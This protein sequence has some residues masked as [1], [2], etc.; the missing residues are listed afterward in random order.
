MADVNAEKSNKHSARAGVFFC[1]AGAALWGTTGTAQA[2]APTGAEPEVVGALRLVIGGAV[3][4]IMAVLR[5]VLKSP[6]GWPIWP[7]LLAG[8][9]MAAYQICFFT[10]VTRTGVAVGTIV[11]I[12]SSPIWGGILGYLIRGERPGRMW[13]LATILAIIGCGLLISGKGNV[14]VDM[15]GIVLA[16]GAGM[17]YAIFS[18]VS[19][20]LLESFPPDA[21]MAVVFTIG[22][23]MLCPILF[24][25]DLAWLAQPKGAAVALHLG[26]IATAAS[27]TLYARGLMAVPVATAVT[28]ALGEPL[29]A[30]ALGII[31]V[32]ERLPLVSFV[33]IA[34]LFSGLAVLAL[35]ARKTRV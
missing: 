20:R 32:G 24:T 22:G 8:A 5:G 6:K 27:Y 14:S 19:K 16:L 7:A 34:L 21:V 12:G 31:V 3:L 10:A 18:V 33:G 30:A 13:L 9:C 28:L 17:T 2:L 25:S 35:G 11:G 29:T 4:L 15:W 23:L 1:L 26:V